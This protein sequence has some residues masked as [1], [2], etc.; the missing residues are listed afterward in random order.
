MPSFIT[1]EELKRYPLPV[2]DKQWVRVDPAQL[3]AVTAY[4]TQYIED[5]LDRSILSQNYIQR[6]RGTN[7]GSLVLDQYPVT[8]ISAITSS[9]STGYVE[10]HSTTDFLINSGSGI[11]EWVD[12]SRNAFYKSRIYTV[13][14]TAGYTSVPGPIKH[15]TALQA[16]EMLQPLFRGG[17]DFTEVELIESIDEAIVDMLEKYKRK[18]IG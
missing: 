7:R 13:S 10:T 15:A 9:D 5:Y 12:R 4:A 17:T 14:Y 6:I 8:A 3:E 2:T 11:I 18:R 16:V 1:P